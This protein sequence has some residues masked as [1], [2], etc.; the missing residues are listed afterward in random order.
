MFSGVRRAPPSDSSV[1][2]ARPLLTT[3]MEKLLNRGFLHIYLALTIYYFSNKAA[4][5]TAAVNCQ[6]SAIPYS[7]EPFVNL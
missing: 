3:G 1:I 2:V 6:V 5:P 7:W 4:A